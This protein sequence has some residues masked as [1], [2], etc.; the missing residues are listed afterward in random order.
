MEKLQSVFED[1]K[2]DVNKLLSEYGAIEASNVSLKDELKKKNERLASA[3]SQIDNLNKQINSLLI[4]K[5]KS[6]KQIKKLEEEIQ[7]QKDLVKKWKGFY[8]QF[9]QEVENVIRKGREIEIQSCSSAPDNKSK[10]INI[11]LVYKKGEVKL[12]SISERL[13]KEFPFVNFALYEFKKGDT[14]PDADLYIRLPKLGH[15]DILLLESKIPK[16]FIL[17]VSNAEQAFLTLQSWLENNNL[18]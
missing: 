5:E 9:V 15:Q 8:Y 1:I 2:Q 6:E 7:E 14:F 11:V 3:N 18:I 16:E 4:Q 13:T 17:V 10:N 12:S